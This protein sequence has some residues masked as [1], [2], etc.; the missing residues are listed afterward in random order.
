[1]EVAGSE[2]ADNEVHDNGTTRRTAAS[3]TGPEMLA[4]RPMRM[5]LEP[6]VEQQLRRFKSAPTRG[7]SKLGPRRM[8]SSPGE[9]GPS[10]SSSPSRQQMGMR[11]STMSL[12]K[13]RQRL[14]NGR[15][16]YS[17]EC[18][19][20]LERIGDCESAIYIPCPSCPEPRP[21]YETLFECKMPRN[22]NLGRWARSLLGTVYVALQG[23]DGRMQQPQGGLTSFRSRNLPV[24][25]HSPRSPC[26][27]SRSA[28]ARTFSPS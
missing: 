13:S 14:N 22:S 11:G 27:F 21:L 19:A 17:T 8:L 2:H 7:K 6:S 16:V 26:E 15:V 28:T 4:T 10:E 18:E 23:L 3:I 20:K 12:K 5:S 24:A 25:V 9:D 1:M